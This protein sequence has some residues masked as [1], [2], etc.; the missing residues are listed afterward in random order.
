M[1]SENP[2]NTPTASIEP[3]WRLVAIGL[4]PDKTVPDLYG[5]IHQGEP[6]V[7]L[8]VD[9][10]I[11]FFTD[12][13]RAPELIQKYGGAWAND[14]TDVSK[15]TLWCDIAQALHHLSA[16]GIDTSTSIVDAVNVLLDLVKATGVKIV[17][18][19]RKALYAIADYCTFNKDLT[20]YLEEEGD[21]SS[22]E[23]VD[24]VLWC[25]GAIVVKSRI[26]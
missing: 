20:K 15:P 3:L 14:P 4:D 5:A 1:S 11:V 6:D 19:R 22:R 21:Y 7:P 8:M 13:G 26:L 23:L 12:P 2:S 9:G 17:D 10:R 16:G 18:G 25:V 24:A